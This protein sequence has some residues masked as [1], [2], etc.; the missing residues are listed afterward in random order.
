MPPPSSRNPTK[1]D[2][3]TRK[4]PE[5]DANARHKQ[6]RLLL[7]CHATKCTVE[8]GQCTVTPHCAEMK[9]LWKHIASCKDSSCKVRHCLSSRYMVRHYQRC[10][11]STCNVCDPV[12]D[13]IKDAFNEHNQDDPSIMDEAS[14]TGGSISG[15]TS[16][17][18]TPPDCAPGRSN[19]GN[20]TQLENNTNKFESQRNQDCGGKTEAVEQCNSGESSSQN[21]LG[22]N[23]A[24]HL[25]SNTKSMAMGQTNSVGKNAMFTK[26]EE[27]K[28]IDGASKTPQRGVKRKTTT[29]ET[30]LDDGTKIVE[31]EYTE[32]KPDG[33]TFKRTKRESTLEKATA[34]HDGSRSIER[35]V[36]TSTTET[37]TKVE[38][39]VVPAP[40][41]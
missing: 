18:Q 21:K 29:T 5:S 35:I 40:L 31:T 2:D 7:L 15:S 41:I 9:M 13:T 22:T 16:S 12:K 17:D 36:T 32:S 20:K 4:K 3:T 23:N 34:L 8:T 14:I 33:T 30:E 28:S 1:N 11:K 19:I 10:A 38:R 39:V 25:G 27:P 26:T 6:Q 37:T 24:P